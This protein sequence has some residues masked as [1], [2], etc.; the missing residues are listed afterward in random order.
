MDIYLQ[1]VQINYKY[2]LANTHNR[3]VVSNEKLLNEF[4]KMNWVV[5]H[6]HLIDGD[7]LEMSQ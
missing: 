1:M 4:N 7:Y 5:N 2:F 3:L 6:C